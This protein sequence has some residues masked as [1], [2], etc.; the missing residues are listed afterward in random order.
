MLGTILDSSE[1]ALYK[2]SAEQNKAIEAGRKDIENG[3][4][5]DNETAISEM[6]EWLQKK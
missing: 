2:L 5:V 4:F 1:Q 3:N 6:K